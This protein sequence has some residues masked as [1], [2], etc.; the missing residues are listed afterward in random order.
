MTDAVRITE[1]NYPCGP[2]KLA[3][4]LEVKVQY[5]AFKGD[6]WCLKLGTRASV[7]INSNS[8]ITRQR[9]TL[10]HEM[11]HLLLDI[12]SVVGEAIGDLRDT[13]SDEEKRVNQLAEQI[14]LP[15]SV[16]RKA[17][18]ELPISSRVVQSLARNANVSSLFVARR[19]TSLSSEL[20]L[21]WA[22][23]ILFNQ[24][25]YDWQYR[26]NSTERI[27]T[28]LAENLL[29]R[30]QKS[31]AKTVKVV[32]DQAKD[33]L[34]ATMFPNP[35]YGLQMVWLQVISQNDYSAESVKDLE[36]RLLKGYEALRPSLQG[37]LSVMKNKSAQ[38][39]L[40]EAIAFFNDRHLGESRRWNDEFCVRL[41]SSDGQR[42]LRLRLRAW[43]R[44]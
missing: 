38:M 19:L 16:A 32:R 40:E 4:L 43:T 7:M 35:R 25:K 21:L 24:G 37:T 36:N 18:Q 17:V 27:A 10:A 39:T 42:Y 31:P 14:L 2:E 8:P 34:V 44:E 28:E 1:E 9:F 13:S 33:V 30:C 15:S 26:H 3:E 23:I 22:A 41:H 5:C 12:P 6:G 11:G 29:E 20:G